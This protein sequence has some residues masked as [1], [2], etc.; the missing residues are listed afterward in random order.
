MLCSMI[1]RCPLEFK[2]CEV[3]VF[4]NEISDFELPAVALRESSPNRVR[5]R[6]G[7]VQLQEL[8]NA[9]ALVMRSAALRVVQKLS[10]FLELFLGG[11]ELALRGFER[12]LLVVFFLLY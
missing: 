5:G 11:F 12:V 7:L 1:L 3:C 4:E 9:A 6:E 10:R 2:S 8:A